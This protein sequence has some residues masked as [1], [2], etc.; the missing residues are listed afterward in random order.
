[1]QALGEEP[2][3][4][5]LA[6]D[7]LLAAF[8]SEEKIRKMTPDFSLLRN[9]D[10]HVVIVTA[11]AKDSDFVSRVFA[12]VVGINEDPVTGSAHTLL[13][14]YWSQKLGK[15]S[16]HAMQISSRGGELF[17][18]LTGERVEIGGEAVTYL[19]GEIELPE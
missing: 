17:C 5:C 2:T 11:T 10:Y 16:L 18:K 4:T 8:D 6:K 1:M 7:Y 3:E 13:T 14:P 9:F 19:V 15:I 12:P